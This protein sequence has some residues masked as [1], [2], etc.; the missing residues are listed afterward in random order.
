LP[1]RRYAD[2]AR[3]IL[4]PDTEVSAERR[5]LLSARVLRFLFRA[6]L[7]EPRILLAPELL[8]N[9]LR[10]LSYYERAVVAH[11]PAVVGNF[12]EGVSSMPLATAFLRELGIR[13]VNLQHGERLANRQVAFMLFDECHFWSA[14]YAQIYLDSKSVAERFWLV[15][16]G[17]HK[18]LAANRG[19][20]PSRPRRLVVI[21][22]RIPDMPRSYSDGVLRLV[23]SLDSDWQIAVRPHPQDD[24]LWKEFTGLLSAA[25]PDLV[26]QVEPADTVPLFEALSRARIV[27]GA[28]STALIE[29]WIGG[30]KVVLVPGI[31]K[32]ESVLLPF[33]GSPNVLWLDESVSEDGLSHFVRSDRVDDGS[34]TS[35]VDQVSLVSADQPVEWR[36]Q[37]CSE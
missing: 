34:E 3:R 11:R 14:K 1:S 16:S 36:G 12:A 8:T 9:A 7:A 37:A 35:R 10:W 31:A 6:A 26:V 15:G 22:H 27:V 4:G 23:R 19:R 5:P 2:E 20:W 25:R 17:L 24:W 28:T 33:G 30:A 18:R 21:H 29:A 32:K 13:S